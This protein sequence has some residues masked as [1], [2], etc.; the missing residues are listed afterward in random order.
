MF[1]SLCS[2]I[3]HYACLSTYID[4]SFVGRKILQY[5]NMLR[6]GG[7]FYELCDNIRCGSLSWKDYYDIKKGLVTHE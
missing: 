6:I 2:N 5:L 1:P 3:T 4:L 7:L